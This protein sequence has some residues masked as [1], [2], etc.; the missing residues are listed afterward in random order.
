MH[1]M[2]FSGCCQGRLRTLGLAACLTL[3][4]TGCAVG[5]DYVRPTPP[6]GSDAPAFKESGLWTPASPAVAAADGAWWRAYGDPQLD[7]LVA[8]ANQA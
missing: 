4:V 3:G 2:F 7:A 8:Q 1:A 6:P 5:P